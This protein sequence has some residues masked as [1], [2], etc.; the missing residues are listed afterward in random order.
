MTRLEQWL[1]KRVIARAVRQG[2]HDQRIEALLALLVDAVETEFTED[3]KPT[4]DAYL[5]ERLV[6]VQRQRRQQ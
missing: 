1:T 4:R 5:Q 2:G 6:A 3:N